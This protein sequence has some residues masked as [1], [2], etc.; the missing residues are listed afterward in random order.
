MR[1]SNRYSSIPQRE[2]IKDVLCSSH[3]ASTYAKVRPCSS[4]GPPASEKSY[5]STALGYQACLSGFRVCY[6]NMNKLLE[7]IQMSRI[8]AKAA[9]FFDRMA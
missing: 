6:F 8:E 1:V 3:P 4:P 9:K 2:G 5:I 7:A